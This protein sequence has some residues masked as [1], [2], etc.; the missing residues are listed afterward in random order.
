[1]SN[2]LSFLHAFPQPSQA[3]AMMLPHQTVISSTSLPVYHSLIGV[4]SYII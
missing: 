3:S 1:M 4:D 2:L